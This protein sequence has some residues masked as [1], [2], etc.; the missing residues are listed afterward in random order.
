MP[1]TLHVIFGPC[2]AGK[3]TYAHALAQREGA[4]PFILD[5]WGAR[6]FGP[7][8]KGALDFGWMMARLRRCE[9]LIWAT[10]T[11]V[12]AAGAP[13]V[14]DR[15]LMRRAE[16]ER[17]RQMAQAAGLSLKWHFVDAPQDVRRARI[18]ARNTT[19]GETFAA[20]VTPE[21][22]ELL[23]GAYEAPTPAELDGA[24]LNVTD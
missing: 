17:V 24:V 11:G 10:A 20:E 5:E 13:V 19:K 6:L 12:L 3:T 21:M 9:A 14:L 4:V 7:D 8:V 16:R 1:A 22:F 15:G 2:G 18:A 23:E